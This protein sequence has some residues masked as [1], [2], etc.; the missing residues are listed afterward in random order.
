MICLLRL[1]MKIH[2][3]CGFGNAIYFLHMNPFR[4]IQD[5]KINLKD[6]DG[7]MLDFSARKQLDFC[8]IFVFEV[9]L[10]EYDLLLTGG[11]G[12]HSKWC[13]VVMKVLTMITMGLER[14]AKIL[15]AGCTL[16]FFTLVVEWFFFLGGGAFCLF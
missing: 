8:G 4:S 6:V 1:T 16:Q 5:L 15:A 3:N 9:L 7:T 2:N 14:T 12:K 10:S 11:A 13:F